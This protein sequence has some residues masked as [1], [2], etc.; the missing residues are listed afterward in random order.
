MVGAL[1][2][3]C[4]AF[5]DEVRRGEDFRRFNEREVEVENMK[6]EIQQLRMHLQSYFHQQCILEDDGRYVPQTSYPTP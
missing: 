6:I 2:L 1:I 5:P 4:L 3:S